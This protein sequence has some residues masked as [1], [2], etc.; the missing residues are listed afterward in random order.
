MEKLKR[1]EEIDES[2]KWDLTRLFKDEKAYEDKL[3][4]V[5]KNVDKLINYKNN[6][7]NSSELLEAIEIN[8]LI[9]EGLSLVLNYV[10]LD[11]ST[12]LTNEKAKIR[13]QKFY[14][15]Y[16]KLLTKISFFESEI[17]NLDNKILE[18]AM[19]KTNSFDYYLKKLLRKK[20]HLLPKEGEHV[21]AALNSA[22]SAPYNIY[23][24]SKLADMTFDSFEIYG[25]KYE[26]S[27]VSYENFYAHST[28]T[29]VRRKSFESFSKGLEKYKNTF[30]A[31]YISHVNN[32]KQIA[33]L[34]GFESVIDYLLFDQGVDRWIYDRQIDLMMEKL[35]PIMRKYSRLIKKFYKLDKMTFA[36]LKVP[37]DGDFTAKIGIE[38]T[39]IYV[40]D[41]LKVMGDDYLK[42]AMSA[43]S[44]KWIDFANNEGKSTGG[45]CSSPYKHGS[46]ILLSFTEMLNE[47]YTLIHE[48][49]HGVHFHLAQENNSILQEE[50]SL[51]FIEA[52]STLNELLLSQSLLKKAG[53][54]RFKRFVYAAQISNTYFHNCVTHLLEAAY[55]R[56]VY[57]KLDKGEALTEKVLTEIK[58]SVLKDFWK[59][60]VEIDDYAGLTWMRQPHYYMGLYSYTYSSGLSIATEVARRINENQEESKK[61]IETLSK[62][63]SLDL[64]DLV[65]VSG[66][67]IE[68]DDFILNTIAYIGEIVDKIEDLM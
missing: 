39:K 15:F 28:D 3:E 55:Q 41:A 18:E 38:E 62:G 34:K 2:L 59:D 48:I 60:D 36:D 45:F 19:E 33:N 20:K 68:K 57:K 24:D 43:Y 8:E 54:D 51:Y 40:E 7:K 35:S 12:D 22:T 30:A 49:G 6:I 16:N 58:K 42:V 25:K 5:S 63:G 65:K 11:Y 47:V 14:N 29:K 26:N 13:S 31:I 56:E 67:D 23:E 1:R 50:P 44:D 64:I 61:W 9:E 17:L 32:E 37:I 27:F 10:E 66:V 21:L 4:E 46:Y 53:S 52:P